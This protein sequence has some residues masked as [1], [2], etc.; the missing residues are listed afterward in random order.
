MSRALQQQRQVY[1]IRLSYRLG[2]YCMAA[3]QGRLKLSCWVRA[4]TLSAL[5]VNVC[6]HLIPCYSRPSVCLLPAL[7]DQA[8]QLQL[9]HGVFTSQG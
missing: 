9:Q 1:G 4:K 5:H 2:S 3:D 6:D 8:V 7:A